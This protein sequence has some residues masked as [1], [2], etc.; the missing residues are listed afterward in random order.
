MLWGSAGLMEG[1]LC[2]KI[3]AVVVLGVG[4]E[5]SVGDNEDVGTGSART[6]PNAFGS[7]GRVVMMVAVILGLS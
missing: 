4:R 7:G 5:G 6:N 2:R 1:S 3:V